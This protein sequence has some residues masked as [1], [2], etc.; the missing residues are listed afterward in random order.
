M[1][2]LRVPGNSEPVEFIGVKELATLCGKTSA[3][4]IKMTQKGLIPDANFRSPEVVVRKG[5]YAGSTLKG[6][7]LYSLKVLAPVIV[8]LISS[9]KW[10]VTTPTE[11]KLALIEAFKMEK[12]VILKTSKK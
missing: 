5:L 3:A 10:G 1:I 7:R 2:A 8:P 11:T 4:L 12:E 6:N 9:I